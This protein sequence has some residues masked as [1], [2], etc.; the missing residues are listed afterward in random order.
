MNNDNDAQVW[1]EVLDFWFP[2]GRS[3]QIDS[4]THKDYWFWRMRGGAD[5]EIVDRFSDLTEKAAAGHL[6]H[7]AS[8]PDGRLALIIVL[9][10]FSRSVWRDSARAFAQ[11]P[12]ALRLTMEGLSNGHYATLSMPWFKIVFGL[13]L[14]HCEGDDHLERLDLLIQLRQDIADQVPAQL[15]PIYQ[16]LVKQA[17]D[18]REIIA[19]FGRH[20]HRNQLLVRPSTPAEEIYIVEKQFPHLRAFKN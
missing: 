5:N 6:D 15:M 13:P 18:V 3:L 7:W 19:T 9:D 1:Q 16:S 8:E 10:Q 20:P 14:G 2:E 17:Q 11:D 12:A 4:T